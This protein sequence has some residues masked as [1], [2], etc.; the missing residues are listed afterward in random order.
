LEY[1]KSFQLAGYQ[2]TFWYGRKGRWSFYCIEL[3]VMERSD[4]VAPIK[5]E[6][7]LSAKRAHS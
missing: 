7:A 3:T 1:K 4:K 6:C 5:K 2:Y